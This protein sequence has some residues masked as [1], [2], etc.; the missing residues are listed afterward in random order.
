MKKSDLTIAALVGF[1]DGIFFFF[2]LKNIE[3]DIPYAWSLPVVLAFLS[4]SGMLVASLI[5]K[6]I[7]VI[8]Q[9]ARFFLV[10]TLNTLIDLAVLYF[11]IW[12]TDITEGLFYSVFAAISFLIATIN[13]Y[14]W[15]K[16]WTFEK[17]KTTSGSK[18]FFKFFTITAIGF[19]INVG[20]ASFVVNIIGP[21]FGLSK[22][23]WAGIGKL[24]AAFFAFVWNFLG[25]K[26][27]VFRK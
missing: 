5:G 4:L 7:L 25:S 12:I 26:F 23:I 18:E 2:I 27:V 21:Q 16:Y 17:K 9:A 6:K 20:I 13:S 14:L 11:F 8:L 15:N 22:R 24:I 1:L 10:G 19:F 3:L